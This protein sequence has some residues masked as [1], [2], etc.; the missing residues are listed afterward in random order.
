MSGLLRVITRSPVS[1]LSLFQGHFHFLRRFS[2]RVGVEDGSAGKEW[3]GENAGDRAS[4]SNAQPCGCPLGVVA[5][6]VED[7]PKPA[8]GAAERASGIP[9]S[10]DCIGL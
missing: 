7:P 10:W 3:A 5:R 8:G 6:E 1:S 2:G 4:S 9:L